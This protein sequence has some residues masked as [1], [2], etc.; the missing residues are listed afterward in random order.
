MYSCCII[1]RAKEHVDIQKTE[2]IVLEMLDM[3]EKDLF[4]QG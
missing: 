1:Y 4:L 3:Y 2:R